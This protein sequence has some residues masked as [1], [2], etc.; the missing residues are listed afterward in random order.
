MILFLLSNFARYYYRW[1]RITPELERKIIMQI[2][3]IS[4]FTFLALLQVHG[5]SSGQIFLNERNAPL[6]KILKSIEKQTGF[7]FFYDDADVRNTRVSVKVNDVSIERALF[8]SFKDSKLTYKINEK[9]IMI[10]KKGSANNEVSTH[11]SLLSEQQSIQIT[12]R[13]VDGAGKPLAGVSVLVKGTKQGTST[14]GDGR[15][16][17]SVNSTKAVLQFSFIG[18]MT[19]EMQVGDSRILNVQLIETNANL[20]DVVVVGYGTKRKSDITSAIASVDVSELSAN[21]SNNVTDALQGRIAGVS[22]ESNGGAPGAGS[23]IVIRGSGTLGSNAPLVVIDGMPFGSLDGLSP[24]DIQNIEVLKDAAAASIY[25]S[26]AA[27][28]VVLVTTKLGRKNSD[29]KIQL[30]GVYSTQSIPKRMSVLNSEQ[31]VELFNAQGGT[32]TTGGNNTKWQD[33]IFRT[34]PIYKFNADVTGGSNNFLYSL[35]G[36]YLDQQGTII[37]T[38]S[39]SANFRAKS[40]YE[41]GRVKIGETVIYN[42]NTGRSLPPGG[43]QSHSNI[44]SALIMPGSVPVY[45]PANA[46]GGW[47]RIVTGMKNMSNPVAVLNANDNQYSSSSLTATIFAEVRLVDELKYKINA[48]LSEDRGFGNNYLYAYDD[49]NAKLEQ[50]KLS[51]NSGFSN[52]WL[53]EHTLSY[54]KKFGAHD[55]SLLAGFTAQRDTS[56]SF[57]ASGNNLPNGIYTFGSG[58]SGQS[59]GGGASATTRESIIGRVSYGYDSRYLISASIRR[60]GSSIFPSGYQY[61]VFPSVSA[62]WNVSNEEFYRNSSLANFMNSFKVRGSYGLLGNDRIGN[63]STVNGIINHLNFLTNGGMIKGSIPSGTASPQNLKW[64]ETKTVDFGVDASFLKNRLSLIAD[65]YSKTSSGVLLAVPIPPSSGINGTPTV[66]A[67]EVNNRGIEIALDYRDQVGDFNYRV[68]WNMSTI[69]NRMTA[70][71][72][73]SGE[74]QFG[75]LERAIV[76]YPLGSFFLIKTDGIFK[77]QEEVNAH[78]GPNG[79]LLQ[80]N[81]AAGDIRFVDYNNDGIIDDADQQFVASPIPSLETGLTAGLGWK[82]FDMNLLVQGTF[83]N[84]I[85]NETRIWMEKTNEYTNLSTAILDSWS[86][87]NSSSDFPRFSLADPNL[88]ARGNSDRW[89]ETGSYVRIKRLEFGYTLDQYLADKINVGTARFYLSGQNLFTFSKYKGYNPDL[90]NGGNPLSRGSDAGIYPLQRIISL[91]LNVTF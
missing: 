33:E 51:Q 35:S 13:V 27:G 12:G 25:G 81:A 80:P 47:G 17:I 58:A 63:Y 45:D 3:L 65:W 24:S 29:P 77:S 38:N 88:N 46:Y 72:I 91:G 71:T 11:I 18:H 1:L 36:G 48:A 85:Y 79:Q 16:Q 90:G 59:V 37:K 34:A 56:N 4:I 15:Y 64:E 82:N 73:G 86:P 68:G 83:G 32:F 62:G 66:N 60:D 2:N 43:D 74:Q 41:K 10:R 5:K 76:G 22:I 42:R 44:R 54:D 21:A 67:G 20:D 14:D 7:V 8:E 69:R 52:S 84:K 31:W 78:K 57:N 23:S 87:Q 53:L 30:N 61:G 9:D 28:G 19:K 55:I 89:L 40:V 26:R 49:G 70:I 75:N 39:K 6:E 50:P